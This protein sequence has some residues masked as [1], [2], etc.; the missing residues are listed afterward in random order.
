L[1]TS[2]TASAIAGSEVCCSCVTVD[3][4]LLGLDL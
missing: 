2:A 1:A 3:S 4:P